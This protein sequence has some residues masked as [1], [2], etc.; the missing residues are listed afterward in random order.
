MRTIVL[1]AAVFTTVLQS[2]VMNDAQILMT[3]K[4]GVHL[5]AIQSNGTVYPAFGLSVGLVRGVGLEVAAGRSPQ[6]TF[7]NVNT[8]FALMYKPNISL[9]LGG[10]SATNSYGA[11]ATFNISFPVARLFSFYTGVNGKMNVQNGSTTVPVW[12]FAGINAFLTRGLEVF[13]ESDLAVSSVAQNIVIG[14]VRIYF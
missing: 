5:S 7:F 9:S 2:Q 14:G 3:G 6:S 13:I 12:Y 1:L 8:E 11:D 10:H 4:T